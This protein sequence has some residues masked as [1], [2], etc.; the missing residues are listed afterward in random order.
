MRGTR[1]LSWC[2]KESIWQIGTPI[3]E[4]KELPSREAKE[5][6]S[7]EAKELPSREV[8]TSIKRGN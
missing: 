8:G 2:L 4:A 7:R 1:Y 5:L 3:N 6:P